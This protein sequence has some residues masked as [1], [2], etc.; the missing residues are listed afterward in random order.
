[1]GLQ[2]CVGNGFRFD[3]SQSTMFGAAAVELTENVIGT[4]EHDMA[5]F[6]SEHCNSVFPLEP[7]PDTDLV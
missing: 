7:F 4:V 3:L 1:M 5:E 6:V 2:N